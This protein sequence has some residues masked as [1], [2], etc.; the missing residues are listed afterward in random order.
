MEY[1]KRLS[2]TL[3]HSS[4]VTFSKT[5]PVR[6]H[7][8]SSPH[9]PLGSGH[10]ERAVQTSKRILR[11]KDTLLALMIY[12]SSQH[13]ST[14]VSPAEQLM[15][16]KI[17]TTLPTLAKVRNQNGQQ[18]RAKDAVVKRTEDSRLSTTISDRC[19]TTCTTAA[20]RPCSH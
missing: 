17:Q 15:G 7:V 2:V 14:G 12:R 10:A 11:Q 6:W 5:L 1:Q 16:R 19:E 4:A 20:R 13:S 18:V 9:N 3:G 8:T